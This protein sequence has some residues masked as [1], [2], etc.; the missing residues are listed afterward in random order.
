MIWTRFVKLFDPLSRRPTLCFLER[1]Q[2]AGTCGTTRAPDPPRTYCT[3]LLACPRRTHGRFALA[4]PNRLLRSGSRPLQRSSDARAL[5][6]GARGGR[7]VSGST[8]PVMPNLI[9]T[10]NTKSAKGGRQ[11]C[12]R[13]PP[14]QPAAADVVRLPD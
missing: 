7:Q 11:W 3:P 4:R 12:A 13:Q 1:R 14:A 9:F 6:S 8:A 10:H 5:H 2:R